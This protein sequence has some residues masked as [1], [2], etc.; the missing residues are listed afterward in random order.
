MER[1]FGISVQQLDLQRQPW[2][3]HRLYLVC[4]IS[5]KSSDAVLQELAQNPRGQMQLGRYQGGR[6]KGKSVCN[7]D[8]I[9]TKYYCPFELDGLNRS[10]YPTHLMICNAKCG[11][12]IPSVVDVQL[13]WTVV[14]GRRC[15]DMK[16][17]VDCWVVAGHWANLFVTQS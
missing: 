13:V 2:E 10:D 17:I 12:K 9:T 15:I 3:M 7:F 4:N 1:P 11:N 6:G 14:D 16:Y 8:I 5:S